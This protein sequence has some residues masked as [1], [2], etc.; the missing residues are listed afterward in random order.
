MTTDNGYT[1]A[2]VLIM[3]GGTGGHVFP[4]LAVAEE[5][6]CRQV[7]VV[8][9][10]SP[11]GLENRLVPAAAIELER[12]DVSGLRG[13]GWQ[14]SV[15]A[16]LMLLRALWQSLRILR[17]QRPR[18]VLGMGGFVS[19]PGGVAARLLGIPLVVHEQNAIP[20]TTNRWLARIAD[21]V[22]EAFPHSFPAAR[23]AVLIGNPVREAI[24]RLPEPEKRGIGRLDTGESSGFK[25]LVLGGSQGAAAINRLVPCALTKVYLHH[26][27]QVWHQT[28]ER[29]YDDA[30]AEYRSANIKARIEPFIDDMAAAYGWADL[31]I[32][33]AGALT[34]SELAAAGVGSVLIPFPHAID[35]HQ[36]ANARYLQS[37]GGTI[38]FAQSMLD[39]DRLAATLAGL[40]DDPAQLLRMAIA[41]RRLARCDAA[42]RLVSLCLT[43]CAGTAAA[44]QPGWEGKI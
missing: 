34:V 21:I 8:W 31:V 35:D 14:R 15:R 18:L 43:Q 1:S 27:L 3:A 25:L 5:F 26:P 13:R 33:R 36:T 16:P 6:R 7:P 37:G 4:A 28:G 40:F 29:L 32:A 30:V 23:K 11:R 19:G 2:P 39:A 12:V 20:G 44:N 24:V 42:H 9:L 41:A 38:W 17:R 22:L 10:G